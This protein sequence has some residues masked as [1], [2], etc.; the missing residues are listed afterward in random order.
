MVFF[1]RHL[2]FTAYA[3]PDEPSKIAQIVER[4]HNLHHPLLLLNSARAIAEATGRHGDF[5]FVKLAGRWC[6]VIFSSLGVALLVLACGRLHGSFVAAAAGVFLVSNPMVFELAHY[7]KEDPALL[8]GIALSLVAMLVFSSQKTPWAAVFLGLASACA[9]SGKFVGAMVV[10][11]SIYIVWVCSKNRRRDL[12]VMLAACALGFFAVNL[13][14]IWDPGV[15]ARSL[16]REVDSLTATKT[17]ATEILPRG[18]FVS[19]PHSVYAKIYW[20]SSNLVL[21]VL[22]VVYALDALHRRFRVS[23]VERVFVIF[24]LFYILVLS[25]LSRPIERY[26]LPAAAILACLSAFGLVPILKQRYGK[27][28]ALLLIALSVIWQVPRLIDE[29]Q[30]FHQDHQREFSIFLEERLSPESV[31]MVDWRVYGISTNRFRIVRKS[32]AHGD[33]LESLRESGITHIAVTSKMYDAFFATPTPIKEKDKSYLESVK[34]FYESLFDQGVLL[35]E[36]KEGAN[37]ILAR[38]LRIYSI[39]HIPVGGKTLS[40]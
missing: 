18:A 37:S 21:A 6:S 23:P 11:F 33:T 1:S 7:F 17:H 36:W 9:A 34:S 38:P 40:P 32:V 2:D 35:R 31:V 3:H 4:R 20:Q 19:V 24:T 15:A 39:E 16:K 13:P 14:M 5:E 10:P 26:F 29:A 27:I 12:T 22:L 25:C 28:A 8:F 30:G